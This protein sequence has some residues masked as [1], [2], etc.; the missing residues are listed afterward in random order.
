MID[1]LDAV[2]DDVCPGQRVFV[3]HT[4][5]HE[6]H[7]QRVY[8][9]CGLVAEKGKVA[10]TAGGEFENLRVVVGP[11]R[12]QGRLSER[13]DRNRAGVVRIVLLRTLRSEHSRAGRQR[14]RHV[15]NSFTSG[16]E[17][18]REEIAETVR[19][20]D[21][22]NPFIEIRSPRTEALRL[23]STCSCCHLGENGLPFVNSDCGV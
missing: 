14:R 10:V 21:C 18:L 6:L 12:L 11:D 16:N 15:D 22:P 5:G 3:G 4:S 23:G 20:L 7:Q 13:G 1:C 2:K 19:G 9:A 8:S 17:L